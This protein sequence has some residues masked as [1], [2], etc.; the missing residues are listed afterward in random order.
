MP[1]VLILSYSTYGHIETMAQAAAEGA[2]SVP[3]SRATVKRVPEL[4]PREVAE[5]ALDAIAGPYAEKYVREKLTSQMQDQ[6]EEILRRSTEQL[7]QSLGDASGE[8]RKR[9]EEESAQNLKQGSS[10]DHGMIGLTQRN[11][12]SWVGILCAVIKE[13]EG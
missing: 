3:G 11:G 8:L 12:D 7:A 13:Q 10:R 4:M 1:N 6:S 2:R 5:K 9:A